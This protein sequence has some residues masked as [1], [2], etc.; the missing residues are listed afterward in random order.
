MGH[1]SIIQQNAGLLWDD[2]GTSGSFTLEP[3][4]CQQEKGR[5][6]QLYPLAFGQSPQVRCEKTTFGLWSPILD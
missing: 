4:L 5:G 6:Y 2:A 3:Q 1:H